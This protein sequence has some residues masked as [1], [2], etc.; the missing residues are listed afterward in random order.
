MRKRSNYEPKFSKTFTFRTD[1]SISAH[2]GVG[3]MGEGGEGGHLM[4][5]SI[6]F[7]KL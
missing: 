6:G 1:L 4:Y 2:R 3:E 7:E 5:P